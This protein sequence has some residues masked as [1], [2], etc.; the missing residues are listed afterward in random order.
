MKT[1]NF[2]I[3]D[4]GASSGRVLAA[5]FNGE[6]FQL[7]EIHRFE[8]HPVIAG[9]TIYWDFLNL[10]YELKHG[11][12]RAA[13]K[14]ET[15][16]ESLGIDTW[17]VD[18]GLIDRKGHLLGNPVHYRNPRRHQMLDVLLSKVSAEEIFKVSG[19]FQLTIM[20][21]YRL[22]AMEV[23]EDPLLHEADK[24]L[25]MPDL[26]AYFLTGVKLNEASIADTSMLYNVFTKTWDDAILEKLGIPRKL[27]CDIVMPGTKIGSLSGSVCD[28][29]SI[30]SFPV[31][32]PASHDTASVVAGIPAV[33]DGRPWAFLSLGT[34]AV[35]GILT[36]EPIMNMGILGPGYGNEVF[37]EDKTFF[38]RNIT[39]LWI[40]QQCREAWKT[41][42]DSDLS[43]EHILKAAEQ[44]PPL[45]AFIDADD[46][47]FAQVQTDMPR[48]IREYT[49][50]TGQPVP[51][52]MG[53]IARCVFESLVLKF[54]FCAEEM[55][56]LT[57]MVIEQLYL[58]GGGSENTLICQWTA[59]ALGIPVNAGPSEATAS[60]NL[61][62]QMM[63]TGLISNLSQGR[64]IIRKSCA[65]RAYLPG[66][67]E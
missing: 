6:S 25:F 54:L 24:L 49:A 26:F 18:F 28:E 34:W 12:R 36:P 63:G 48:V 29:L 27:F 16:I 4:F 42:D 33:E 17:G 35:I 19:V 14:L 51:E 55:S 21:V 3:A 37:M 7:K 67:R 53:A 45:T 2:L 66:N 59:D 57:G 1:R 43:W 47:V 52:T 39:G 15:G 46:P 22:L 5:G 11:I 30:A 56:K 40:I 23:D 50:R 38:A 41:A 9:D 65:C 44:A 60:G 64:D 61:V 32:A 58:V 62:M 8:N 13:H 31:V 10:L 20:S